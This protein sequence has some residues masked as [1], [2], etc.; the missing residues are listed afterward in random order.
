MQK[1]C[2]HFP[3]GKDDRKHEQEPCFGACQ[4]CSHTGWMAWPNCWECPSSEC[5]LLPEYSSW[6]LLLALHLLAELRDPTSRHAP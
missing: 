5:N 6:V 4:G 3:A 2:A 1:V